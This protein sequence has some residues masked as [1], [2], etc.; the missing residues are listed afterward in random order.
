MFK[1][2]PAPARDPARIALAQA[3]AAVS[4]LERDLEQSEAAVERAQDIVRAARREA[5]DASDALSTARAGATARLVSAASGGAT[6]APDNAMRELRARLQASE[7]DLEIA[8]DALATVEIA[9]ADH[10][11]ALHRARKRQDEAARDTLA[12]AIN[13]A[14][15]RV[16]RL[17]AE[18]EAAKAALWFLHGT[19]FYRSPTEQSARIGGM[20]PNRQ[21]Y[22]HADHHAV[23]P[24]RE[25]LAALA[26]DPDA[27]LPT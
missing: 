5:D 10:R 11:E 12:I 6:A 2:K 3:I 24:W 4:L 19:C 13:P 16:A 17:E 21:F 25:A 22:L 14:I 1:P 26:A 27:P 15:E 18:L 8:R 9:E 23:G 7:D 20:L